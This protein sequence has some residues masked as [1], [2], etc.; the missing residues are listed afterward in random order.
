MK[1]LKYLLLLIGFVI[2]AHIT[3]GTTQEKAQ[4]K[5]LPDMPDLK[6]EK[7]SDSGR[8]EVLNRFSAIPVVYN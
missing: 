3:K 5:F 4:A 8:T 6:E 7:K 1:D 2:L